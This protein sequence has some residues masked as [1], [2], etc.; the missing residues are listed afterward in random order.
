MPKLNVMLPLFVI[1]SFISLRSYLR[2]MS[3]L[4]YLSIPSNTAERNVEAGGDTLNFR[5]RM[6][7]PFSQSV[8][9]DAKGLQFRTND[10]LLYTKFHYDLNIYV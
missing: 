9:I 10:T 3:L 1:F 6:F 8:S 4:L 5:P 2:M 7:D